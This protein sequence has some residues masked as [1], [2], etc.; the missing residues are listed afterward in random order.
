MSI[1]DGSAV[2]QPKRQ[3]DVELLAALVTLVVLVIAVVFLRRR[4][5]GPISAPP[6]PAQMPYLTLVT[7]GPDSPAQFSLQPVARIGRA[8]DNDIVIDDTFP[9]ANTVSRYHALTQK[10]GERYIIIDL[11]SRNGVYVQGQ[12]T[13]RNLLKDGWHVAVGGVEF[14]FHTPNIQGGD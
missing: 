7:P 13:P 11:G 2:E 1:N 8:S 6:S 12:R 4:R 3:D 9:E 5:T 10:E 14:V